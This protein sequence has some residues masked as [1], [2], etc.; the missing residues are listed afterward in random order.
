MRTRCWS[1]T[2]FA[3]KVRGTPKPF[4]LSMTEW[5][6]WHLTASTK[7]PFRYWLAET[8]LNSVQDM[9][10]W[11]V[12]GYRSALAYLNNRFVLKTHALTLPKTHMKP[13]TWR[14]LSDRMLPS[15]FFALKDFV[16]V[17]CACHNYRFSADRNKVP[18]LRRAGLIR[19]WRSPEAGIQ[20][21]E[22]SAQ[23]DD[24]PE[25]ARCAKEVLELYYWFVNDYLKRKDVYEVTGWTEHCANTK[26]GRELTEEARRI[27]DSISELE[28]QRDKEDEEMMIRLIKVRKALWT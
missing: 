6:E 16:E 24:S 25:Y 15:L 22:W 11:P 18:W 14:D 26:L 7:H 1:C 9:I 8:F 21:L 13:G 10:W 2:K 4:A 3:D 19:N 20:Y 28:D 17:E 23:Q 5:D 12:D 27:L